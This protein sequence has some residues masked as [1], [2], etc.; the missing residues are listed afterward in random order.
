MK[1]STPTALFLASAAGTA[2]AFAPIG[3]SASASAGT[4]L[5]AE[6]PK[7]AE[8]VL[9]LIGSTPLVKLSKLAPAD[10]AASRAKSPG[11]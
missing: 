11:N 10:G 6:R 5:S 8:N 3:T 1:F 2:H 9:E 7:I 4:A